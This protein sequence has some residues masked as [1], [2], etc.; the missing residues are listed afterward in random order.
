MVFFFVPNIIGYVRYLLVFSVLLT[1]RSHPYLTA[2]LYALSQALDYIDGYMAR[3]L[4]Q[5]SNF[6]AVLDMVCDRVA[7]AVILAVLAELYP[8]YSWFF[9]FTAIL[10]I[11]S[12]WFQ[13]YSAVSEGEHHK[14]SKTKW[15]V[16]ELYY[17]NI[18]VFESLI[19]GNEIFY[20]T[21]YLN[22]FLKNS[23]VDPFW[24]GLNTVFLSLGFILFMWKNITNVFQLI[25]ASEKI[26]EA[27]I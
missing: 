7:D 24:V 4:N 19:A 17:T 12:H 6:G 5:C 11:T 1:F 21:C 10:D 18:V 16:L 9:L 13:M 27:D 22:A 25:S 15:R 2:F 26:A 8:S 23:T 20:V 14:E 3:K